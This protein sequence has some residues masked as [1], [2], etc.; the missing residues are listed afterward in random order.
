MVGPEFIKW[1]IEQSGLLAFG[2][3]AL[4]FFSGEARKAVSV[5]KT[6]LEENDRLWQ[7]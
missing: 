4:L 1:M 5:I 3:L 2:A 6:E 7:D